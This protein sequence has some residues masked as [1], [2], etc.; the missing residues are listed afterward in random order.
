V[1][2]HSSVSAQSGYGNDLTHGLSAITVL[3][4]FVWE[5]ALHAGG[6][7]GGITP[8]RPIRVAVETS[9][10]HSSGD[11]HEQAAGYSYVGFIAKNSLRAEFCSVAMSAASPPTLRERHA[12]NGAPT[13]LTMPA[14]FKA[15]A[16]RQC[17][18]HRLPLFA[19]GTRRNGAPTVLTMPAGSKAWAVPSTGPDAARLAVRRATA[20]SFGFR[21]F[22]SG[23]ALP[24]CY[25]L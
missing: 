17:R 10:Q 8:R 25:L 4:P 22:A 18:Q 19:K 13:V 24:A 20:P 1:H 6:R 16:T 9:P 3:R 11:E 15:W 23:L 5:R 7:V 14:R 2:I 12:K 21:G